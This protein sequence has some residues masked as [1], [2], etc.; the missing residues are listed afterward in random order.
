[1]ESG[2][3]TACGWLVANTVRK[4]RLE[5]GRPPARGVLLYKSAAGDEYRVVYLGARHLDTW[6]KSGQRPCLKTDVRLPRV[7]K[8]G[9]LTRPKLHLDTCAG[10]RSHAPQV[11]GR[12]GRRSD[13]WRL[14][15]PLAEHAQA[16]AA[17]RRE[18][19]R[20]H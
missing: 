6:P 3:P 18:E 7:S 12:A 10:R 16:H 9:N 8:G 20:K 13:F 11:Q 14:T 1:M 19:R 4:I 2:S 15:G 17:C 5:M